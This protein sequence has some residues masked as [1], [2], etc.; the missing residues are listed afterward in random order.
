M[1]QTL[2]YI[3]LIVFGTQCINA[4][5]SLP[6]QKYDLSGYASLMPS[7]YWLGNSAGTVSD[8]ALWQTVIHNRL[9]FKW[10]PSESFTCA[11]E[12]RNQ[13][14]ASDFVFLTQ[15]ES[16]F[17]KEKYFLPL[18]FMKA[19][20]GNYLFSF[21]VDRLWFQYTIKNLEIKLGRQRIN[22]GQTFIWNPN[23]IF[24][25]Y[26][27]FDFDYPERP[28]ADAIRVQYY[29]SPVSSLDLA[30]KLDSAGDFSGALL[31]RFNKWNTDFQILGGYITQSN[32]L[33]GSDTI[34]WLDKDLAGG[35]G[36]SGSI[37]SLS[38]RGEGSY[39]YSI[40]ENS[41]STN[42]LL[43]SLAADYSFSNQIYLMFE[44]LF[45]SKNLSEGNNLM[46]S[47]YQGNQNV[48]NLAFTKYN[49]FGQ[50]SYPI[51]PI[52][53]ASLGGMYFTD[54]NLHGFY[55]GPTIDLSLGDNLALSGIYQFIAVQPKDIYTG[56]RQ[57]VNSSYVFA[58][59]KWNF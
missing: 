52:V 25:T 40:K 18:T 59:L 27:F 20:G 57:W 10:F 3:L 1:K 51:T 48:K 41:D 15:P 5:D 19:I 54:K 8:S 44:F 42:L 9:N 50:F 28:G 43:V 23:D 26:N 4:Q 14:L 39:F 33:I 55:A 21:S 36:F 32:L 31:F 24:N 56:E 6:E 45:N 16:G 35:M 17:S 12:L 49:F 37:K 7:I 58:R 2:V 46:F 38:L 30:A 11:I 34:R 29:T 22:W 13:F 47:I 53:N